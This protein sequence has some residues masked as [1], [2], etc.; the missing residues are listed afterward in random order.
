M[1]IKLIFEC[2][3]CSASVDIEEPPTGHTWGNIRRT[4]PVSWKEISNP[5]RESGDSYA[6]TVCPHCNDKITEA[7]TRAK[8]LQITL[9]KET[10]PREPRLERDEVM[11]EKNR[12][13]AADGH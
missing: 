11:R 4:I 13:A 9:L 10:K 5:I 2:D 6:I 7:L 1:A 3:W 8:E 12:K